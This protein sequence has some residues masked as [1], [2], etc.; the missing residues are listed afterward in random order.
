M[1]MAIF[2]VVGYK[3]WYYYLVQIANLILMNF[4]GVA[5]NFMCSKYHCV[6]PQLQ[7]GHI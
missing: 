3:L 1:L 7:L 6:R 4:L 5:L 2:A